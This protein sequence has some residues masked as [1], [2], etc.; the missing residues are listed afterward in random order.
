MLK[1][2]QATILWC[3]PHFRRHTAK[4]SSPVFGPSSCQWE[5]SLYPEGHGPTRGTHIGLFLDVVKSDTEKSQG[6]QYSRPLLSFKLSILRRGN[7]DAEPV[8]HKERDPANG[9]GFGNGFSHPRSWGWAAMLPVNRLGEALTGE[10]TLV[11]YGEVVWQGPGEI[12]GLLGR[13]ARCWPSGRRL[14]FCDVLSDVVFLAKEV[15]ESDEEEEEVGDHGDDEDDGEE[16]EDE[17]V[18]GKGKEAAFVGGFDFRVGQRLHAAHGHG[19]HDPRV[20]GDLGDRDL[21]DLVMGS[22]GLGGAGSGAGTGTTD[23]EVSEDDVGAML[24]L[25]ASSLPKHLS[26]TG[27]GSSTGVGTSSRNLSG[28][29]GQY[30]HHHHQAMSHPPS[31]LF[32]HT[33]NNNNNQQH[34]RRSM[35]VSASSRGRTA[36][37]SSTSS[38]NVYDHHHFNSVTHSPILHPQSQL[39][40]SGAFG[41]GLES[42]QQQHHPQQHFGGGSTLSASSPTAAVAPVTA[43]TGFGFGLL[44]SPVLQPVLEGPDIDGKRASSTTTAKTTTTTTTTTSPTKR[45][46]KK[47]QPKSAAGRRRGPSAD[48]VSIPAHRSILASRSDYY[49][50]M[51][52]SGM[53]ESLPGRARS[54]GFGGAA[55]TAAVDDTHLFSVPDSNLLPQHQHQHHHP[56]YPDSQ[57][58]PHHS[59][60]HFNQQHQNQQQQQHS[61]QQQYRPPRIIGNLGIAQQATLPN[62]TT[63]PPSRILSTISAPGPPDGGGLGG[64]GGRNTNSNSMDLDHHGAGGTGGGATSDDERTGNV[65]IHN[66]PQPPLG[67]RRSGSSSVDALVGGGGAGGGGVSS[68]SPSLT[69]SSASSL[70]LGSHGSFGSRRGS[71]Q[72]GYPGHLAGGGGGLGG[73]MQMIQ[74][75]MERH[76]RE[77]EGG[78]FSEDGGDAPR[79]ASVVS[80]IRWSAGVGAPPVQFGGVTPGD[81]DDD[82]GGIISGGGVATASGTRHDGS[83]SDYVHAS[84]IGAGSGSIN[85]RGMVDVDPSSQSHNSNIPRHGTGNFAGTSSLQSSG[86]PVPGKSPSMRYA[87]EAPEPAVVHVRDFSAAAI[88]W[89]LEFLYTGVIEIAPPSKEGRFE[90]IRL[91]DRYQLGDLHN[92][93]AALICDADLTLATAVEILELADQYGSASQD[94]KMACLAFIRENVSTLKETPVFREWV[95]NTDRR[96]LLV[97][98]FSLM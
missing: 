68:S 79:T 59:Q 38:S 41:S 30:P 11:V 73:S 67:P 77:G 91:A 65:N 60:S 54:V 22:V 2:T 45:K 64:G 32:H 15:C 61:Q 7:R 62:P 81:G 80:P 40:G 8:V 53:N 50:A 35:Q 26:D 49:M 97:E 72:Q 75:E 74:V 88:R 29:H 94:L 33:N 39:S 87:V 58:Q 78:S 98:L 24:G 27:M 34:Q 56:S 92:Y 95:R 46:L 9:D 89:M 63:D 66:L 96:E 69:G 52:S 84:N 31:H 71:H 57:P 10:G 1:E 6:D 18:I 42:H 86:L 44:A 51:F 16:D 4:I 28:D 13:V 37:A 17:V 14:L 55:T 82:D 21:D 48:F 76:V 90:L 36:S 3:I 23:L 5:L 43:T 70:V 93:I 25:P 12:S 19:V 83:S 85:H 20:H 47:R